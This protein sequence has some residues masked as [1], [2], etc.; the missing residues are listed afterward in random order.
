MDKDQFRKAHIS[1]E[2]ALLEL[3]VAGGYVEKTAALKALRSLRDDV[4]DHSYQ[5]VHEHAIKIEK[6]LCKDTNN[7]WDEGANMCKIKEDK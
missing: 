5:D 2:G 4:L 1:V 6:Q 7:E 3:S